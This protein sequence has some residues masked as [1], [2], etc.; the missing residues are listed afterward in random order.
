MH[1]SAVGK[2]VIEEK[3]GATMKKNSCI[4][5]VV[6][7]L[8]VTS[9]SM[10]GRIDKAMQMARDYG[11]PIL[12]LATS[13]QCAPC[14]KMK[15]TLRQSELQPLLEKCIVLTMDAGSS[16]FKEFSNRFPADTSIVPMVYV[17]LPDGSQMYSQGGM[18]E[19]DVISGLLS[20]AVSYSTATKQTTDETLYR[21]VLDAAK[22]KARERKL[23]EATKMTAGLAKR[24]GDYAVL[25]ESREYRD[26]LL[27]AVRQW[28]QD[29]DQQMLDEQAAHGAAFRIAQIFV[30]LREFDDIHEMSRQLLV[31]YDQNSETR[32]AVA[33]AKHL[34]KAR[35]R[36]SDNLCKEAIESYQTVV[37]LDPESTS[38]RFAAQQILVLRRKLAEKLTAI[39]RS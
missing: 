21:R 24:S 3:S 19:Q 23:I 6:L 15:E 11:R 32:P 27:E 1:Q 26:R 16:E 9:S 38:G 17:I 18:L 37:D 34:L 7:T 39:D 25:Q 13:D 20:E 2:E 22:Q 14:Q 31:T 35:Y 4:V 33:Q 10:A 30:E 36:Q 28:L 29:L 5:F 12:A 8:L